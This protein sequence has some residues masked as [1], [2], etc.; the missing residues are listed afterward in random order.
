MKLSQAEIDFFRYSGYLKLPHQAPAEALERMRSAIVECISNRKEPNTFD[1]KGGVIKVSNIINRNPIFWEVF[2]SPAILNPLESLL[3]PNIVLLLNR[4]NHATMLLKDAPPPRLHRDVFQ[5]SRSIIT[6]IVYLE[7]S[8]V[9]TGC[10]QIIPGSQYFPFIG[11]PN[12]GG[13]WMDQ[14]SVYAPLVNQSLPIPMPIGGILVFD[15]LIFHS[16][17]INRTDNT[18]MSVTVAYRSVDEL[19]VETDNEHQSLVS[20]EYIYKGNDLYNA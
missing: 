20:G 7:A 15:G 4:H 18:R 13:T 2:T 14:H 10:T 11:L 5:W 17:G 6:V 1:D 12:N 16:A 8:N 19:S 9:E 3:G